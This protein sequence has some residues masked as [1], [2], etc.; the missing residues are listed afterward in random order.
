MAPRSSPLPRGGS[1]GSLR[2][3]LAWCVG[4]ALGTTA[5]GQEQGEDD[6]DFPESHRST[7]SMRLFWRPLLLWPVIS[8]LPTSRVLAT[9]VPPSACVSRPCIS[10]IRIRRTRSGTR[11]TWVRMRSGFASAF[12][13]SSS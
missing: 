6:N 10:T 7:N 3:S 4:V 13:R 1:A 9:W 12:S 8:I 2:G 5:A 11:L